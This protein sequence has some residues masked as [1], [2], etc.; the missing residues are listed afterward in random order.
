[1]LF[2][3]YIII[4]NFLNKNKT[5]FNLTLIEVVVD[6]KLSDYEELISISVN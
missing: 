3:K 2:N 6:V 1:M 4:I 5:H